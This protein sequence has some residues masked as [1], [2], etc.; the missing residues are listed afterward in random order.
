MQHPIVCR[1]GERVEICVERT[2]MVIFRRASGAAEELSADASPL[3]CRVVDN[4]DLN[5]RPG[6]LDLM[7]QAVEPRRVRL[8]GGRE[9]SSTAMQID[10]QE[11]LA[12]LSTPLAELVGKYV[13]RMR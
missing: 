9:P 5:G 12:D 10:H 7:E 1:Y 11:D 8:P 2:T 4:T 13:E 3:R 6:A